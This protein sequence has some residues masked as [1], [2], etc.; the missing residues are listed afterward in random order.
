LLSRRLA[1]RIRATF[2]WLHFAKVKIASAIAFAV[3]PARGPYAYKT[4][5]LT[6]LVITAIISR[7]V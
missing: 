1:I 2:P 5:I 4:N 6:A 3:G 7:P